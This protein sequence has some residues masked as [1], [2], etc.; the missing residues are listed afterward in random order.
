MEPVGI[1][2]ASLALLDP[3]IKACH[4]AYGVYKLTR[5]FGRHYIEAQRRLEGE[6]ACLEV[7]L[8]AELAVKPDN[9]VLQS[10]NAE[11]GAMSENFRACNDL[12]V[13]IDGN[14]SR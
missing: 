11:L 12:V 3:A 1:T 2:L 14:Q 10:I 8:D 7:A 4:S 13:S 9:S 6:K 5:E